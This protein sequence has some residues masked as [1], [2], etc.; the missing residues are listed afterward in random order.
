VSA[1]GIAQAV[2]IGTAL[3]NKNRISSCGSSVACAALPRSTPH[4]SRRRSG[5]S[6]H[7]TYAQAKGLIL[8][9][10][11]SLSCGRPPNRHITIHW[12]CAGLSRDAACAAT[13]RFLKLVRDWATKRGHVVS[14]SWVR[15]GG[16]REGDHVHVL[17]YIAEHVSLGPMQ[18]RWITRVTGTRYRRGTI[19]TRSVGRRLSS[20]ATLTSA[21]LANL[22]R[23]VAYL[24]KGAS[25]TAA[26]ALH[27]GTPHIASRVAGKRV[28]WSEN[29]A[30]AARA[31]S[32]WD[33]DAR[34]AALVQGIRQASHAW[35]RSKRNIGSSRTSS[36]RV[37]E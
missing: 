14:W 21:Y 15:E 37:P 6:R 4:A 30:A 22:A 7:V 29:L 31:R 13:R 20:G 35:D 18:R 12:G 3:A 27:L 8:S 24:L 36:S 10:A 17:L 9:V 23:V 34:T 16:E 32:R 26:E 28:G 19:R 11:Y 33:W 25:P 2:V 5:L 1:S